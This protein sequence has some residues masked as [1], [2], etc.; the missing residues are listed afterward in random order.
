MRRS[1]PPFRPID[2]FIQQLPV[3]GV[4]ATEPTEV[5]VFFDDDNLYIAARCYDS[6]PDRIV[7][8]EL[9]RDNGNILSV[10]D[11]FSVALDTFFDQ[12]NGS[13]SR[14]IRSA[15][16]AIRRLPTARS[17]STGTPCGT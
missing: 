8:N 12:R 4:P 5:W 1:T 6:Q 2:G 11:N 16:C 14:P 13:S 10:N 7:A 17:T 3:E 15:R 9:R